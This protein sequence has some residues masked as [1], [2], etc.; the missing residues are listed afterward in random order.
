MF[1]PIRVLREMKSGKWRHEDCTCPAI[2]KRGFVTSGWAEETVA[3][4]TTGL[5]SMFA[6]GGT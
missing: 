1:C 2:G 4:G 3:A 5:A 6:A